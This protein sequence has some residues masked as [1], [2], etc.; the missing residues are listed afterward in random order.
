MLPSQLAMGLCLPI[1]AWPGVANAA[2]RR[3]EGNI[4]GSCSVPLPVYRKSLPASRPPTPDNRLGNVVRR[5]FP[6]VAYSGNGL[7]QSNIDIL[8]VLD[9]YAQIEGYV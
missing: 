9:R 7:C 5:P 3:R 4:E 2:A 8:A 1:R 6:K